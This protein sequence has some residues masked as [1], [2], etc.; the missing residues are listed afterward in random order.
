MNIPA[1]FALPDYFKKYGRTEP[2]TRTHTPYSFA[3]GK[4]ELTVWEVMR[5]D[6]DRNGVAEGMRA[7]GAFEKM[8]PMTG[9]YDFSWVAR[10]AA[11]DSRGTRALLVDV[12]ASKGHVTKAICESTPG[13]PMSRC[14]LQ[15]L[16]EVVR[17]LEKADDPALR[18]AQ[19]MATDFHREQ[20]VKG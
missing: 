18:D 14:V 1:L 7:F 3:L 8:M 5:Q 12:G 17:E 16:P 9:V 4:P 2:A 19:K 11:A 10:E 15:D 6:P 20:P 13:L